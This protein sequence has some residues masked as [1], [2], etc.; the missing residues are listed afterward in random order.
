MGRAA[1][2]LG[3]AAL[4]ISTN[5]GAAGPQYWSEPIELTD[6]S[7]AKT[8]EAFVHS[9][10][11]NYAA[12]MNYALDQAPPAKSELE[13]ADEYAA[14]LANIPMRAVYGKLSLR[15]NIAIKGR[16]A[17]LSLSIPVG[18]AIQYDAEAQQVALCR[19]DDS[20]GYETWF[21]PVIATEK[22]GPKYVG[23]NAFGVKRTVTPVERFT[24]TWDVDLG[25]G[26]I[27]CFPSV[28]LSREEAKRNLPAAYWIVFGHLTEGEPELSEK[29]E[30]ATIDNPVRTTSRAASMV[31]E[32]T[33]ILLIGAPPKGEPF[34][35]G[36]AITK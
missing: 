24:L 9:A 12:F 14:R 18:L 19:A 25:F 27:G 22:A 21:A 28:A 29:V 31:F 7:N 17:G 4:A 23:S 34:I 35:A 32:A 1:G 8:R 6:L 26:H 3:L 13:T 5:I 30:T 11:F 36:W 20:P 15:S 33:E 16:M 10:G 2:C